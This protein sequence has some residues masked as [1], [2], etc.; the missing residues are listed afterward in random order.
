MDQASLPLKI[1][2]F[3]IALISMGLIG[4]LTPPVLAAGAASGK[5]PG[6]KAPANPA[7]TGANK[8]GGTD[9]K[10]DNG[11]KVKP[12]EEVKPRE[13]IAPRL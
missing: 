10:L 8:S 4:M 3:L 11:P 13:P 6:V 5:P 9:T 7:G 1:K 12:R 2:P